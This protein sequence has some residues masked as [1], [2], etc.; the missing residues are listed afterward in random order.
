MRGRL[1]EEDGQR[2]IDTGT[3]SVCG[4]NRFRVVAKRGRY[5][6]IKVPGGKYW[7]GVGMPQLYSPTSFVVLCCDDEDPER[8]GSQWAE[9]LEIPVRA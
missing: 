2:W 1:V 6:A 7:G 8:P 3:S 4:R 5:L 9:R